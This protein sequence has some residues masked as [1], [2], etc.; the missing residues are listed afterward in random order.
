MGYTKKQID[1]FNRQKY[2]AQLEKIAKN[3]FRML[4]DKR[5][6]SE[7]FIDKFEEMKKRLDEK[8]EVHLDAAYFQQLKNYIDRLY[9]ETCGQ[10]EF[11]DKE[12]DRIRDAEVS[13]MNR[14]QK[15]KNA[16]SY[17]KEKYKNKAQN[18]DWG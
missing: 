2:M 9:Q 4:R 5:I 14:L 16:V 7:K 8:E 3:I 11:S 6:S 17:K 1:K 10:I 12:F 18:I 13:N 15:L